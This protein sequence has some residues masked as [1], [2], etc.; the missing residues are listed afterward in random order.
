VIR[1]LMKTAGNS[2]RPALLGYLPSLF[3]GEE[4]YTRI[5]D[6]CARRGLRLLEIGVPTADPY[7][8]GEVIRGALSGLWSPF[9]EERRR[10]F[11]LSL[12][13]LKER[14]IHGVAMIYHET[15][16]DW[17]LENFLGDCASR[18]LE[19]ILVPNIPMDKRSRLFSAA[20]EAGI[21]VVNFIG[22]EM[23]PEAIRETAA[24]TSGFL[25]FQSTRGA[26]G[27][28]FVPDRETALRLEMVRRAGAERGLPVA[29]GFG[30]STPESAGQAA[31]L[32]P[33][34][35]IVGTAFVTAAGKGAESMDGFLAGFEP[36]LKKEAPC[37]N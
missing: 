24:L 33:D 17:G 29:M 19:G 21:Q 10:R 4:E 22:T 26:T 25:Y 14:G 8:D 5:L 27:G 35:I 23:S 15:L 30:I 12:A 6:V 1:E 36:F 18:G 3:P 20:T 11:L 16:E 34:G 28:R 31:E 2:G 13:P 7:L 32:R 9:R 37:R